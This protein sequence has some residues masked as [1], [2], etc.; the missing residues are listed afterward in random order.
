M[1]QPNFNN[2]R[3]KRRCTTALIWAQSLPPKRFKKSQVEFKDIFGKNA[4]ADLHLWLKNK[5]LVCVD[6]YYNF[7]TGVCK[8]YVRNQ[9]GIEQLKQLLFGSNIPA[10]APQL[11]QQLD[12]GSFEYTEKSDRLWNTLQFLPKREKRPLMVKNNYPYHYDIKCCAPTLIKQYAQQ[13]AFPLGLTLSTPAIDLYIQDRTAVRQRLALEGNIP[14]DDI[15]RVINALFQGG[16]LSSYRDCAIY[17]IINDVSKVKWLQQDSY[18]CQLQKDIKKCWD[19]I[20]LTLPI[21][22]LTDKNGLVRRCA[23][24]P[25]E[26]SG[27]Y[28]KLEKSVLSEIKGYMKKTGN[29]GLLEHDGWFCERVIDLNE[30]ICLIRSNTGYQIDFDW[31]IYE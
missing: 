18:I 27:V 11:Q 9:D 8:T 15:K 10:I 2:P 28:L 25:K 19:V 5:L 17:Q 22:T 14:V 29:R 20:K 7:E 16:K 31:T 23:I 21:R 4:T 24:S 26:K 30:L 1:Y 13:E 12:T 3:I 6:S